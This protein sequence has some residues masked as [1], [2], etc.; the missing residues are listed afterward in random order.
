MLWHSILCF[1]IG[2]HF[3]FPLFLFLLSEYFGVQ[4]LGNVHAVNRI[5]LMC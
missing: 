5:A 1:T 4:F 2:V 3:T